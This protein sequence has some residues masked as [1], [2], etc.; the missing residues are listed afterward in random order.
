MHR[1]DIAIVLISVDVANRIRPVM[2]KFK[3]SLI[4]SLLEIPSKEHPYNVEDDEIIKMAAVIYVFYIIN[5][6]WA[7]S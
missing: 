3:K 5:V 6:D 2:N 4:P 1:D 7:V